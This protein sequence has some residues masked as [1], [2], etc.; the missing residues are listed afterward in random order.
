MRWSETTASSCRYGDVA[1]DIWGGADIL[2]EDSAADYQGHA[3]ILA[4]MADGRYSFYE[5]WYGSCSGC[6]A[7]EAADLSDEQVAK[8]MRNTAIW[9][10][11]REE[12]EGWLQGLVKGDIEGYKA[13][14]QLDV[15][16]G[17]MLDVL[18]GGTYTR[19]QGMAIAYFKDK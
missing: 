3:T 6:D 11:D 16:L 12:M 18:S 1:G 19:L 9:F 4:A 5:W 13:S 2:W 10:A 14:R 8:E 7:W 17:Q 15:E